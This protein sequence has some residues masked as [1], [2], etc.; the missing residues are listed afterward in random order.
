MAQGLSDGVDVALVGSLAGSGGGMVRRGGAAAGFGVLGIALTV[1]YALQVSVTA[2]GLCTI[3]IGTGTCAAL[4]VGPRMH[5]ATARAP[6]RLIAMAA[7][8]FLVGVV[9]RPWAVEQH[10]AAAGLADV[11]TLSGY[12]MLIVGL[13]LMLARRGGLDRQAVTDGV[14]VCLGAGLVATVVLALPAVRIHNRPELISLLAGL[15]PFIDVVLLLLVLNLGFSTASRLPSFRLMAAAM[16]TLFVGDLGYAWI[17][18]HGRLTGSAM[19]DLPFLL[20]YTCFGAA[21]LHPSMVGFSSL[22]AR[23]MPATSAGVSSGSPPSA[24]FGGKVG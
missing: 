8:V 16:A 10:G 5:R 2:S 3:V 6:W 20:T 24:E 15:Y 18:A 23:N 21:A 17:G 7:V 22:V 9:I 19:L 12:V 1:V 14:I 13:G 4:A 11:F